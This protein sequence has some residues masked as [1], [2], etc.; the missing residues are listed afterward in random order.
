VVTVAPD[1][2]ASPRD[3]VD[4]ASDPNGNA[5]ETPRERLFIACFDEQ[6]NVIGLHRKVDD[7]KPRARRL[8]EGA[9]NREKDDLLAQAR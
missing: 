9:T 7:A 4:C 8:R 1:L 2:A 6:V 3:P 5:H